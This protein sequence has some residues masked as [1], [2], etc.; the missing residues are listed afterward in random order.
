MERGLDGA[1][2]GRSE[3]WTGPRA[4]GRARVSRETRGASRAACITS[5]LTGRAR[6]A[7]VGELAAS[8]PVREVGHVGARGARVTPGFGGVE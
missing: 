6:D 7:S 5:R 4:L 2:I 8:H 1:D 3:A